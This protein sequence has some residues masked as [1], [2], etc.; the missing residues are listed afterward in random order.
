MSLHSKLILPLVDENLQLEDIAPE[1]GF[2]DAYTLD[3]NRPGLTNHIFLLYKR[4]M[5]DEYLRIK[6]KLSNLPCL[7]S[8]RNITINGILYI[9]FC[10]TLNNAARMIKNNGTSLLVKE[11]RLRIGKFWQFTDVDITDFLLG[12]YYMTEFEDTVLPEEDYSP[13]DFITYD[14]KREELIISSSL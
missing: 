4:C 13:S 12:Y 14:E 6:E 11:D 10:F 2:V 1:T 3:I 8:K 9:L 5:T 7:Y